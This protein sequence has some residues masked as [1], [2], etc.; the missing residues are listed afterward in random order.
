[1]SGDSAEPRLEVVTSFG[2]LVDAEPVRAALEAAGF[3]V[4]LVDAHTIAVDP[5][6]WPG[7]GGVKIAVPS[8]QAE[9]AREFLKA[10]DDGRLATKGEEVP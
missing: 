1:M 5:G 3:D 9:E 6:L 4:F 7:L 2:T 10:A 8:T